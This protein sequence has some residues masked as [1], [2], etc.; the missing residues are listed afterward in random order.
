[1]SVFQ[2][3]LPAQGVLYLADPID[4]RG[5]RF[6][7]VGQ[8]QKIVQVAPFDAGPTQMVGYPVR[9]DARRQG[10]YL[11]KVIQVDWIGAADG[12]RYSMHDQREAP[13]YA[14]QVVQRLAAGH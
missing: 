7:G 13:A 3:Y 6:F 10:P 8:G 2:Q 9:F 4:H 5:Q 11:G 14:L 12:E 1:M